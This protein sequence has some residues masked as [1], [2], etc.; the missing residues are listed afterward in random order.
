VRHTVVRETGDPLDELKSLWRYHDF[1]VF[2]LRGLFEYG[3]VHN[4]DDML[5]G[6]IKAGVRPMLAAAREYRSVQR[7][8]IAYS[9]SMESAKAMKQFVQAMYW[10]DPVLRIVS[11]DSKPERG[12][13]LLADAAAYCESHGLMVE[14]ELVDAHPR[15]ELLNYARRWG[16]DMIVMGATSRARIFQHVLGDTVLTAVRG[17]DVPLFLSQ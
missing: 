11:F 6:L 8:L 15:A 4:P 14:T 1:T 12:Q 9:G 2:G 3:V 17:S 16:A 7:V 13:P 10:A 5:I